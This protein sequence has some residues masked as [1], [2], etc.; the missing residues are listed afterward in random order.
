MMRV[1]NALGCSVFDE[2]F[3]AYWLKALQKRDDPGFE[4][5]LAAHETDPDSIIE[6]VLTM[7]G[8]DNGWA[9]QK[10]MAIHMLPE[11]SLDWMSDA[12]FVHCFLIRD[13][14]EVIASM[15]EFRDLAAVLE[16][17][18]AAAA[19]ALVGIPQL[20]RIYDHVIE[21]DQRPVVVDANKMLRDPSAVL[22]AFCDRVGMPFD[23]R[24]EISWSAGQ[25]K[26]D[27]AWAPL[28]YQKVF[29]TT[30]LKPYNPNEQQ[31]LVQLPKRMQPVVDACLPTY[32]RLYELSV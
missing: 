19:A 2:P 1:F 9:Y 11:V 24:R 16:N 26:D 10:H 6:S 3:Y 32:E 31:L 22:A 15:S 8:G 14:R 27:G 13:P 12:S 18:G 30:G 29:A 17:E 7:R 20:Q 28:W 25:H 5:T 23:P 21:M 4:L